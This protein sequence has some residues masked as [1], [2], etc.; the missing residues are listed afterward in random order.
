MSTS[1]AETLISLRPA[2]AD[3]TGKA[4]SVDPERTS[5]GLIPYYAGSHRLRVTVTG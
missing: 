4:V 3:A 5:Y 1:R 2:V